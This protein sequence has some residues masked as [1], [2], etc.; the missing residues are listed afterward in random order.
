MLRICRVAEKLDM[1]RIVQIEKNWRT[2]EGTGLKLEHK[3]TY[4]SSDDEVS[5]V[6]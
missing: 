4:V 2:S 1:V 5:G 3:E 6:E